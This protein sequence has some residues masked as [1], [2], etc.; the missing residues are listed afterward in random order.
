MDAP[1][2]TAAPMEI[3]GKGPAKQDHWWSWSPTQYFHSQQAGSP[4]QESPVRP[5]G[6]FSTR[7]RCDSRPSPTYTGFLG[8]MR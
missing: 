4:E 2:T 6:D 7:P 1:R 3:K 5:R 8:T